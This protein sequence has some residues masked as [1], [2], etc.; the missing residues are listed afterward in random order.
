VRAIKII[1]TLLSLLVTVEAENHNCKHNIRCNMMHNYY[2]L[3]LVIQDFDDH[4]EGVQEDSNVFTFDIAKRFEDAHMIVKTRYAH[5]T[6]KA[7]DIVFED[8]F[9]KL[10]PSYDEIR[11]EINYLF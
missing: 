2:E 6:G 11:F 3:P 4:K 10:N 8:G 1:A 9:T 7:G 5:V